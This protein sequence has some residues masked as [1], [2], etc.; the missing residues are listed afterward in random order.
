MP[1][2][3]KAYLRALEYIAGEDVNTARLVA[4]RVAHSLELIETNSGMGTPVQ[5]GRV[6]RYPVPRAG[7]GFDYCQTREG[8][9][10]VRW[11]RQS[12]Q[13]KR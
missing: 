8:I 2:A 11:Y 5:G 10:I 4:E 3:R 1:V 9:K 13:L 6:R 12:Q 7:H